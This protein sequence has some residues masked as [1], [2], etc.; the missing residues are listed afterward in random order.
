MCIDC[1]AVPRKAV[2]QAEADQ[3]GFYKSY[4]LF[5]LVFFFTRKEKTLL[6]KILLN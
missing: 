3:I 2:Q 1:N 5:Y 4:Q 6:K